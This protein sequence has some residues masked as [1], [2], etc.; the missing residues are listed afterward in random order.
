MIYF[1]GNGVAH[2]DESWWNQ[3][4]SNVAVGIEV[5]RNLPALVKDH[6]LQKGYIDHITKYQRD[7]GA[8][9]RQPLRW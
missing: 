7:L 5:A 1:D 4:L 6:D 9:L 8:G 2:T 3:F